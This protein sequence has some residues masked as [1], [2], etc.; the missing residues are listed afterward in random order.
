M[1]LGARGPLERHFHN[2][3]HLQV[4]CCCSWLFASRDG[5]T[6]LSCHRCQQS[7]LQE[8]DPWRILPPT[9]VQIPDVSPCPISV[10]GVFV[11]YWLPWNPVPSEHVLA[12]LCVVASIKWF[13]RKIPRKEKEILA[14]EYPLGLQG[15]VFRGLHWTKMNCS[16]LVPILEDIWEDY[17]GVLVSATIFFSFHNEKAMSLILA[18]KA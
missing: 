18:I 9:C 15:K 14:G 5:S 13:M 8:A 16:F 3:I 7:G 11:H 10:E 12:W 4:P 1:G 2:E 6:S 17:F